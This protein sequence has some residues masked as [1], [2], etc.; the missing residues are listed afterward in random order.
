VLKALFS[1]ATRVKLLRVFL[2]SA[3]GQEYFVRE[4]TRD[5]DEQ[6]N[7]IRRELE[8]LEKIGMLTSK[9]RERKKY[10][11]I[12][13]A[14]TILDELRAIFQ[15][16]EGESVKI[17]KKIA[18]MG[19][20]DLLILSGTFVDAPSSVDLAVVGN[21][22]KK[23]LS[24]YLSRE[25]ANELKQEIRYSVFTREDFIYRLECNDQ[26]SRDLVTGPKNVVLVNKIANLIEPFIQH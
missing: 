24:D 26:F 7:S 3:D 9:T 22:D 18:R 15:K 1:S 17:A 21:L 5:L 8:N 23:K 13:P 6:I 25:L 10:Y 20:L 12:N 16:T 11:K 2:L 19:R 14:F 4:L